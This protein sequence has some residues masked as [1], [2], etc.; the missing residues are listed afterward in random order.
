[1]RNR[2]KEMEQRLE[3]IERGMMAILQR[4]ALPIPE[5]VADKQ[6]EPIRLHIPEELLARFDN[7]DQ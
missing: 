1:M 6:L 3:T 5:E 7:D 4:L 2:M